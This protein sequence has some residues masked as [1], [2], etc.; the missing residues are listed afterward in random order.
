MPDYLLFV[1][2]PKL[3]SFRMVGRS[4]FRLWWDFF[5]VFWT[6]M[7]LC[8]VVLDVVYYLASIVTLILIFLLEFELGIL[9]WKKI[10]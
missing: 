4:T 5:A 9:R 10:V 1:I 6:T 3:N 7:V 8:S 2:K